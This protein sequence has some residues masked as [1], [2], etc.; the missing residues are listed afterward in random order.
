MNRSVG[1]VFDVRVFVLG[2]NPP[3]RTR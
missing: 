3:V 2:Y 1:L